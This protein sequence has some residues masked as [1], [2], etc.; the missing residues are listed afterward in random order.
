MEFLKTI[1]G[2]KALTYAE[3]ETALKDNKEIKLAN[4]AGGQ[5]VDKEKFER[6]ETQAN[7]LQEQLKQRDT[8]IEELKKVDAKG[9]QE[10]IEKLQAKYDTDTKGLNEKLQKQTLDSKI[11]LAL[12][13]AKAKNTKAVRA[14]LDA[15]AIKLDGENVLGLTDQLAAIQKDNPFLFGEAQMQNPPPPV[16]GEPPK[17]GANDDM[18]TW[19]AEAGLPPQKTN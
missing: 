2:E 13:G 14:L 16:A 10:E 12:L 17:S 4:L 5:Y 9:L 19:L 6:A 8:D 15:E 3:L 7:T 18:T 1:F 11:D